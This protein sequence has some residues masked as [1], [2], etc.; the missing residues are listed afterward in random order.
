MLALLVIDMQRGL[1]EAPDSRYDEKG[2]VQRINS[3]AEAVRAASGV[4]SYIQHEGPKGEAFEP[5][6]AGWESEPH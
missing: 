6:S 1:F 2:V 3:L 5:G 4:V